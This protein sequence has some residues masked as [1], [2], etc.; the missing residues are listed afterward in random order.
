[1]M[2]DQMNKVL[3]NVLVRPLSPRALR[4]VKELITAEA[5][6]LVA[7]LPVTMVSNLIGLPE[8]GR[9]RMLV[10][11]AEMFNCFGPFNDRAAQRQD[12]GVIPRSGGDDGLRHQRGGAG[13]AQA[14]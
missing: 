13:K 7:R 4:P 3:R 2:N 6:S 12:W 8:K 9:E 11:A 10:W 1:M 5:E 14:R